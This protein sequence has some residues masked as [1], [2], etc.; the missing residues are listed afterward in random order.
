MRLPEIFNIFPTLA[1][2]D[3]SADRQEQDVEEWI[4]DFR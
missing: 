1:A 3:D 4:G 2:T